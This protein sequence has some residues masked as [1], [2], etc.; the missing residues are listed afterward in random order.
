MAQQFPEAAHAMDKLQLAFKVMFLLDD[1]SGTLKSAATV[2]AD[3]SE[4]Q[5]EVQASTTALTDF[6]DDE[7]AGCRVSPAAVP[8]S[9]VS[10]VAFGGGGMP[11]S[12]TAHKHGPRK[13]LELHL[14]DTGARPK[15]RAG[16]VHSWNSH[17]DVSAL[18]LSWQQRWQAKAARYA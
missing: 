13:S 6:D 9:N 18:D 7:G 14:G 3:G 15:S 1:G 5:A 8:S 16:S 4:P 10:R 2:N 12:P 17:A 11:D